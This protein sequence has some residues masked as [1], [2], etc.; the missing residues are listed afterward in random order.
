M[1]IR[2][3]R[4]TFQSETQLVLLIMAMPIDFASSTVITTPAQLLGAYE[5]IDAIGNGSFWCDSQI[6]RAEG[7]WTGAV[8]CGVDGPHARRTGGR[9]RIHTVLKVWAPE[10]LVLS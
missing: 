4:F 10:R 3:F 5:S 6:A 7:G 9:G 8:G 2:Q 1:R